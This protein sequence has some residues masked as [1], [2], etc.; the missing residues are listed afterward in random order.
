[1]DAL[2]LENISFSYNGSE[3]IFDNVNFTLEY[4]DFVL[5]SGVSGEGKSTLLSIING[6]IPFIM[7]GKLEGKIYVNSEDVTAV[8][9]SERAKLIG[10]VLQNADEQIVYDI[11]RDEIAFGCE[12]LDIP[13]E[14]IDRRIEAS[15]NLMK[16]SP[17]A[18]T[19]TMSGGQKQRLIT[20]STLAMIILDEPLANLDV[21]G[22]HVLLGALRS[23]ANS[24]YAVLLVEHRLDV[25]RPYV[26]KV[27]W[28]KDKN[29]IVSTD[30]D[31]VTRSERVIEPENNAHTVGS[32][33]ISG[34]GLVFN[35]G[36]RNILDSLDID[37]YKGER[38]VLL[39]TNG[40]GKTTLMRTLARL[41]KLTSG[42]LKQ[43][44]VQKPGR[45]KPNTA[46]FKNVGFV[47]Q[48]PT[49]QLF[50]PTLLAEVSFRASSERKAREMIEAFG[51]SGLENRSPFRRGRNAARVSQ[52]YA[53][54]SRKCCSSTSLLSGRIIIILSA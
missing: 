47:Y 19:R 51:L 34:R 16:I 32:P 8:R 40:C 7:P 22:A 5:L 2:R 39:G 28:I 9:V 30:K 29:V 49:Y 53:R 50:M 27:M 13:V 17:D 23:L 20:A 36:G 31:A 35:A 41:N 11:V 48:N 1:M 33:V 21:E 6:M 26:N 46:W 18:K 52:R 38:L 44:I 37:V 12:N 43:N 45:R 15:T 25:V 14:T 42:T 4:G 54:A 24:G 3:K 10:T